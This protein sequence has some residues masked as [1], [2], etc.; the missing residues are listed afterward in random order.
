MIPTFS[1]WVAAAAVLVASAGLLG[2][3]VLHRGPLGILID[4][5]G[6][7]SLTRFQLVLWSVLVLSLVAGVAVGRLLLGS[8][9]ALAFTI[10]DEL[11]VAMGISLGSTVSAETIKAAKDA[12]APERIAASNAED[13]PRFSQ[14]FLAEEGEQ[15][16]QI[17]DIAK[18]QNFWLTVL[19]VAAYVALVVSEINRQPSI[20]Q[21][22]ALPGF[23]GTLATL[24]GISH[25]AYLAGKLPNQKSAPTGLTVALRRAG[26]SA[27]AAPPAASRVSPLTYV[28]RNP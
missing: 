4:G 12:S 2:T 6:R 11:L 22:A 23:S 17:V 24:L 5:R 21:L 8:G 18:F 19:L 7:Y 1:A 14:V 16:D 3:K 28:P 27:V 10:P 26:A 15:A 13:Q 9:A 20:D 25:A